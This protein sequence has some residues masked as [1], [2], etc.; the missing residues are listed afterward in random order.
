[1]VCQRAGI[2][3]QFHGIRRQH[4]QNEIQ[5]VQASLNFRWIVTFF[6][7][8]QMYLLKFFSFLK[9]VYFWLCWVF[10][11]VSGLSLVSESGGYPLAA[12]LGLLT[13]VA[14]LVCGPRAW[15][16]WGMWDLPGPGIRSV[17]P[18]L[19]GGFLITRE[20]LYLFRFTK[21]FL[22]LNCF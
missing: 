1:M 2:W 22:N 12:V 5:D 20:V 4:C 15:L 8:S 13:V 21:G 14:P 9:S 11:A 19:A 7:C 10:V 3:T 6:V 18:A 17:S 16:L